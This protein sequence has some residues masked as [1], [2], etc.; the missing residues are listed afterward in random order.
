MCVF[1]S[2]PQLVSIESKSVLGDV[3]L[4]YLKF[5]NTDTDWE[6]DTKIAR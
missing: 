2:D 4:K 1:N 6:P 3:I 5:E